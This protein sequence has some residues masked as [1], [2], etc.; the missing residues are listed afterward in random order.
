MKIP[1]QAAW[2]IFRKKTRVFL[3][4]RMLAGPEFLGR[5][6]SMVSHK[7]DHSNIPKE[8]KYM[9]PYF[10]ACTRS[11]GDKQKTIYI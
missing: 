9:V 2:Q 10:H 4:T 5:E 3:L 11:I 6:K 8:S 7:K 1:I